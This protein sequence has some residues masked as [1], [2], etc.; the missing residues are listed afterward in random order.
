[1][2]DLNVQKAATAQTAYTFLK[3]VLSAKCVK[4]T[5]EIIVDSKNYF[6][7]RGAD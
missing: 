5:F 1:M 4:E 7:V 2:D 3:L 6:A